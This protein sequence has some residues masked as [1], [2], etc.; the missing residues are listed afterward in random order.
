VSMQIEARS[1]PLS[2]ITAMALSQV[3]FVSA[4]LGLLLP[5]NYQAVIF[6]VLFV[7]MCHGLDCD[8]WFLAALVPDDVAVGADH[9]RSVS[10]CGWSLVVYGSLRSCRRRKEAGGGGDLSRKTL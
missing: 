10:G 7:L 3:F 5:W 1:Y 4:G 2:P 8:E 9:R 6:P